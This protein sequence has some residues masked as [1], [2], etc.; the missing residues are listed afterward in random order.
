MQIFI[1]M[2]HILYDYHQTMQ[3]Q[4][5]IKNLRF[6]NTLSLSYC[7]QIYKINKIKEIFKIP[8]TFSFL[9]NIIILKKI[10]VHLRLSKVVFLVR[11]QN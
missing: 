10:I 4:K 7:F 8:L 5:F 3:E 2:F 11:I 1:I 6:V 9:L